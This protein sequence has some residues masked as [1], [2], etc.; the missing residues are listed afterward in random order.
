[1]ISILKGRLPGPW[2][3]CILIILTVVIIYGHT[4]HHKFVFDDLGKIKTNAAIRDLHHYFSLDRL[5][6]PRGIVD[7][8]FA[9]NYRFGALE[10]FGY[11]LVNIVIHILNGFLVY[12]LAL[13]I[14]RRTLHLPKSS[15]S[16]PPTSSSIS[17]RALIGPG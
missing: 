14:F 15:K 4:F 16:Y 9:L 8:T 7:F 17:R 2:P 1:M 12:F 10:V 11:H 13:T 5:L 6:I 3:A